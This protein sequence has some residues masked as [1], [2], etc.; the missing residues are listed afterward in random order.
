MQDLSQSTK[1]LPGPLQFK[2]RRLA[3]LIVD[4][5]LIRF[6]PKYAYSFRN[7]WLRRFGAQ[8]GYKAGIKSSTRILM[9][10]NLILHDW[11]SFGVD[12]QVMNYSKVEIFSHVIV[13]QGVFLCGGSHNYHI[14]SMPLVSGEIIIFSRS[15]ICAEAFIG[16]NVH[17]GEDCVVAARAVVVKSV[18]PNSI[19]GG[20]PARFI[21]H[22]YSGLEDLQPSSF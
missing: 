8:I 15:W 7:F 4:S 17:I 16:P 20:N 13:S 1:F 10:W 19:V 14:P 3:W 12:V 2:L 9:P 6:S 11:I 21:K 18:G 22:R 5:T